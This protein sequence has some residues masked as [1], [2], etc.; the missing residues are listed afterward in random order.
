M[1]SPALALIAV[2]AACSGGSSPS[3]TSPQP[4][5][6]IPAPAAPGGAT[7]AAEAPPAGK[8]HT[9]WAQQ[10]SLAQSG[11]VPDWIDP[12]VDPC[13]DF[14]AFA[15]GG[16]L[17][18][19]T[20]PPDRSSWGA[21][22]I[23]VKD[24]EDVLHDVLDAAAKAPSGDPTLAKIGGYYAACM[25]ES[26]IERA[27]TAPMQPLLDAIAKVTDGRSAAAAVV[28]LQADGVFPMFAIG[29]QQ[30]FTDA[31]QVIAAI[32]QAGL[33]LPD[34]KYYLENKGN[35]ARTREAYT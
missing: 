24:S 14:F 20:I 2:A 6:A 21:I 26:A 9:Q 28:A 16:F 12:T 33:G 34:R 32:D 29:P 3:S 4:V 23:V 15:C 13:N 19:A 22:E 27:G 17:K 25:D 31:T 18:T 35:M 1:R 7:P 10:M 11:I 30:D 5:A 8:P